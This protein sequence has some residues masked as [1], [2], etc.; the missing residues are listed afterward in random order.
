MNRLWDSLKDQVLD[1]LWGLGSCDWDDFL[2]AVL[3]GFCGACSED[4][5]ARSAELVAPFAE[6]AGSLNDFAH[7]AACMDSFVNDVRFFGSL[8]AWR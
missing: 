1:I 8:S 3:P 6:S 5:R 7:F 4:V 2:R